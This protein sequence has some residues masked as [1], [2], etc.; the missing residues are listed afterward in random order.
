MHHGLRKNWKLHWFWIVHFPI[1]IYQGNLDTPAKPNWTKAVKFRLDTTKAA[2]SFLSGFSVGWFSVGEGMLCSTSF[3]RH[4]ISLS[5]HLR[6]L[7]LIV[8]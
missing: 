5:P 4:I 7:S 1:C 6:S 3:S 8:K 2:F